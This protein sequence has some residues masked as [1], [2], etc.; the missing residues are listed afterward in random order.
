MGAHR[1]ACVLWPEARGNSAWVRENEMWGEPLEFFSILACHWPWPWDKWHLPLTE[2]LRSLVQVFLRI[3]S[4][5]LAVLYLWGAGKAW[6]DWMTNYLVFTLPPTNHRAGGLQFFSWEWGK[7]AFFWQRSYF[8]ERGV[9]IVAFWCPGLYTLKSGSFT[10]NCWTA[11]GRQ[12]RL[13]FPHSI[14]W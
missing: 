6:W 3:R 10:S 11:L 12:R 13:A 7:G 8:I 1:C 5:Q 4:G 14:A 2:R 9:M